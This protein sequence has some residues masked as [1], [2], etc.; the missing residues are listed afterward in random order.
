GGEI[1][2]DCPVRLLHGERDRE[3]PLEIAF[4]TM[5]ALRSG[6]VQLNVVKGSDH[7]LSEAHEIDA[8]LQTV[9]ALV[10]PRT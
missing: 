7:R 9:A 1:A 8:M 3:V 4:R 2:V 5:R 10:E 6:D